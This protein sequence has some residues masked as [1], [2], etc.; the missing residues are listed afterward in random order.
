MDSNIV[1]FQDLPPDCVAAI[2]MDVIVDLVHP[3]LFDLLF[4]SK[5]LYFV[6]NNSLM[7][8]QLLRILFDSEIGKQLSFSL[9]KKNNDNLRKKISW[10]FYFKKF[11]FFYHLQLAQFL[12]YSETKNFFENKN[13]INFIKNDYFLSKINS[14]QMNK[15]QSFFPT[16][17]IYLSRYLVGMNAFSL[18]FSYFFQ[19]NFSFLIFFVFFLFVVLFFYFFLLIPLFTVFSFVFCFLFFCSFFFLWFISILAFFVKKK[20]FLFVKKNPF[21]LLKKT[22]FISFYLLKKILFIFIFLF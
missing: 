2:L 12:F 19:F 10:K 21:Y 13:L 5:K 22:L 17:K 4:L 14:F 11:Y 9:K 3:H 15:V 6:F 1:T 16:T 8:F 7:L 20:S 18:F